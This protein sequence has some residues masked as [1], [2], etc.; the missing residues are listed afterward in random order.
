MKTDR[1]RA[2]RCKLSNCCFLVLFFCFFWNTAWLTTS[3]I[4][5]LYGCITLTMDEAMCSMTAVENIWCWVSWFDSRGKLFRLITALLV[6]LSLIFDM[7]RWWGLLLFV[8]EWDFAMLVSYLG[9][10][11]PMCRR[12]MAFM[13]NSLK[14]WNCMT[15]TK[16]APFWGGILGSLISFSVNATNQ[17]EETP[18]HNNSGDCEIT[19]LIKA[20]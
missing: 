1:G 19:G 11:L 18:S 16:L 5:K 12:L 13:E 17:K 2:G 3:I 8:M 6:T 15:M 9:M 20:S 10:L 4:V 14:S 7:R